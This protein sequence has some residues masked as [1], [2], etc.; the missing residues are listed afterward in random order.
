MGFRATAC[1]TA[2]KSASPPTGAEACA[3]VS[4]RPGRC[5]IW[6]SRSGLPFPDARGRVRST[7][8]PSQESACVANG[9]NDASEAGWARTWIWAV[10]DPRTTE[11]RRL[12]TW[13]T[14]HNV[15]PPERTYDPVSLLC[16]RAVGTLA[17]VRLQ[18]ARYRLRRTQA[19]K[20]KTAT[21]STANMLGSG[22]A[23]ALVPV[24]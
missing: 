9:T 13:A 7:H 16:A 22:I 3:G 5:S 2:R 11:S 18:S 1:P 24:P 21:P 12:A 4:P 6:H 17:V 10:R 15:G 19:A 23:V 14:R 8:K 20:T